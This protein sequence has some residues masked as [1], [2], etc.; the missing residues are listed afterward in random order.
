MHTHATG[1]RSSSPVPAPRQTPGAGR[2]AFAVPEPRQ[3]A[4]P[5][6]NDAWLHTAKAFGHHLAD[7]PAPGAQPVQ[8]KPDEGASPYALPAGLSMNTLRTSSEPEPIQRVIDPEAIR[9]AARANSNR[10]SGHGRQAHGRKGRARPA[11]QVERNAAKS[12]RKAEERTVAAAVNR[13]KK[14]EKKNQ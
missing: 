2:A 12:R 7:L 6:D 3:P 9:E 5:P 4:E 11:A 14:Q 8:R 1:R 13:E 10:L